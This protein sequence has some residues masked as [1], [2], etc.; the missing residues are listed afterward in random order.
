MIDH[1]QNTH[2]N[3]FYIFNY[4]IIHKNNGILDKFIGDGILAIFGFK[5][6]SY[7]ED[8]EN[9][10]DGNKNKQSA[11]DAINSAI[12][13]N[14]SFN[15]I[16]KEWTKI[17]NEQFNIKVNEI[18]LKCGIN[19]GETLIGRIRTEMRDEFTV[20]G[21]NVNLASRLVDMAER[22]EILISEN[23]KNKVEKNFKVNL[24]IVKEDHKIQSFENIDK[25]YV[26][27]SNKEI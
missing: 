11:I 19:T 26:V 6:N 3:W 15:Q 9:D 12:E 13:L 16:I 25:Y 1:K 14:E 22:N 10:L 5:N 17:W 7:A 27:I 24:M 23:T 21:S 4:K 18:Y 8:N 2:I 20:F